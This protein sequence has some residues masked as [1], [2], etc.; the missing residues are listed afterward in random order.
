MPALLLFGWLK[1]F[2]DFL[3]RLF[4]SDKE[5]K[6]RSP[7]PEPEPVQPE[8]AP[9]PPA[10][11][12]RFIAIDAGHGGTDTGAVNQ[13][14]GIAEK[15]ITLAISQKLK[16]ILEAGGHTILMTRDED[17]FVGL[18]RRAQLA[19]QAATEIFV[20]IHCNSSEN[21][22]A[23]GIESY[24]DLQASPAEQ[25]LANKVHESLI[26]AFP[27]HKNRGVKKENFAVLRETQM[28]ACLIEVEFISNNQQAEFLCD[29]DNQEQIAQ[30]IAAGVEVYFQQE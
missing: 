22:S 24:H 6:P 20:S 23:T 12:G 28:P 13:P 19:N 9:E 26:A 2:W 27:S 21:T 5:D 17:V 8:P 10:T 7:E 30:A 4:G 18:G 15:D 1:K 11:D 16:T 3:R 14:V 25:V 29:T